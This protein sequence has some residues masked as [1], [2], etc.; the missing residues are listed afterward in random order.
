MNLV[1][2][3]DTQYIIISS[4]KPKQKHTIRYHNKVFFN[5]IIAIFYYY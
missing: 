4:N 3:K 1:I 2:N 5:I